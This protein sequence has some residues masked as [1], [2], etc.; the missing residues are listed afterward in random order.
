MSMLRRK[1]ATRPT[2]K[3]AIRRVCQDT[4]NLLDAEDINVG[5]LFV[6]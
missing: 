6:L 5:R 3:S 2:V 4:E 1:T